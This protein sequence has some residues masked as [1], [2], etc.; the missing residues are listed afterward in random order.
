[1]EFKYIN[2][3]FYGTVRVI[4]CCLHGFDHILSRKS[5]VANFIYRLV[6]ILTHH[7]I[8]V[9]RVHRNWFQDFFFWLGLLSVNY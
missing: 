7:Q 3:V 4:V 2:E 9:H 6:V 8:I 5:H 1:M